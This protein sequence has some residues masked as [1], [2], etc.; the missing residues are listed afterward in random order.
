MPIAIA[1]LVG[2]IGIGL[3]IVNPTGKVFTSYGNDHGTTIWRILEGV[4]DDEVHHFAVLR[5]VSWGL[6][7]VSAGTLILLISN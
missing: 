3:H 1:I 6:I 5:S 7:G 4:T 2:L